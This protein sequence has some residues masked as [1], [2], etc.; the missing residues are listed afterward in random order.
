MF[1]IFQ[2]E[3]SPGTPTGKL[4]L[5]L[6]NK[7]INYFTPAGLECVKIECLI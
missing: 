4:P 6:V 2:G 3:D 5:V 1:K 7:D